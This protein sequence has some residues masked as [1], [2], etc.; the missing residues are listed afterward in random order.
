MPPAQLLVDNLE[1]QRGDRV[2]FSGLNFQV[3]AG[4]LLLVE[5]ENG[6]GKTSLLRL[7]CGLSRPAAGEV[8]WRG[9][10]I[11]RHRA[12][13]HND[14]AYFGHHGGVKLELTALENLVAASALRR[15]VTVIEMEEALYQ[16]GLGG[17]EDIPGRRLSA[18]QKQRLALARLLL[19]QATLWIMDEP[20]TALDVDG[21][22]LVGGLLE[23]HAANG[24]LAVLTS[25]QPVELKTD[26][27]RLRLG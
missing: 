5:G 1:C 12:Q 25:H 19:S 10:N 13:F 26:L 22:A 15:H 18:G 24:G 17:F 23:R 9:E 21:I 6:A 3:E 14:M 4:Q 11:A 7:L 8:R 20:F 16:V 2:L 27:H